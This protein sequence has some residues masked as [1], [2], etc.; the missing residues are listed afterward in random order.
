MADQERTDPTVEDNP[1]MVRVLEY[2]KRIPGFKVR[3]TSVA[4]HC[5][6]MYVFFTADGE[7]LKEAVKVCHKIHS[8]ISVGLDED[9]EVLYQM[10]VGN[11]LDYRLKVLADYFDPEPKKY[12]CPACS[13]VWKET[14][15]L[16][17]STCPLA[18]CGW[19]LDRQQDEVT[20]G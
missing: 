19:Q 5:G 17:N 2:L 18:G 8:H 12:Q 10:S 14:E 4:P 11:T 16:E 9:G 1:K 3:D 7:G 15:L 20:N 13:A 6:V